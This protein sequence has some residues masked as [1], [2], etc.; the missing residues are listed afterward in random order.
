MPFACLGRCSISSLTRLP[1][2]STF[3]PLIFSG[4]L[5][6]A[7]TN[8]HV[9]YI[10]CLYNCVSA[11][12]VCGLATVDLSGLTGFQQALLFV[13]MCMGSPVSAAMNAGRHW[14]HNSQV[15]VSVVIVYIRR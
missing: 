14:T 7:N 2:Y 6:A 13:Q 15:I 12:T 10:D 4:I 1:Q 3:T 8:F 9:S 11:M 5:Y